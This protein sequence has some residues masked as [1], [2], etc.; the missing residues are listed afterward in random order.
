[1]N[2]LLRWIKFNAVGAI[3]VAVQLVTLALLVHLFHFH[4]IISTVI[5][6]ETAILHNFVWH[7]KW[8]WSDLASK[9]PSHWFQRLLRFH[10]TNGLTSLTGNLIMMRSLVGTFHIPVIYANLVAIAACSLINFALSNYWVF[11]GSGFRGPKPCPW[12]LSRKREA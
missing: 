2:I 6:V 8:T 7:E 12:Y 9:S 10:V 11:R 1:M 4:Y 5:A 3:G